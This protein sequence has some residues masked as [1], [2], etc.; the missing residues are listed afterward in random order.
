MRNYF[1]TVAAAVLSLIGALPVHAD[2]KSTAAKFEQAKVSEPTMIAFLRG[3]PK[4]GDLHNHVS[5][6]VTTEV[7]LES[8]IRQ[9]LFFDPADGLFY[10]ANNTA[11]TRVAASVL[12]T[13]DDLMAQYINKASMSGWKPAQE[14]G[15]DH[16]FSAFNYI[17]SARSTADE[18]LDDVVRSAK[19]ENEQYLELMTGTAPGSAYGKLAQIPDVSDLDKALETIRP[20]LAPFAADSKAY[21]DEREQHMASVLGQTN[22]TM[23][24]SGPINVRYIYSTSRNQSNEGFFQDLA[25]A[26]YTMQDDP[27]IVGI[28]IVAPEDYRAARVNFDKQMEIIDYLHRK[29]PKGHI[30]LHAGELTPTISPIEVMHSRIR[31]S[32]EKGDAERIGHGVSIAWEDNLDQLFQEMKQKGTAIEI[33]L[34]SNASILGVEGDRHPWALYRKA[35]IPLCL[36]TDDEGVS[37]S[38]LTL[39]YVRAAQTY[40][41][42]YTELKDLARN[43]IEYSF[44]PGDGIYQSRTYSRLRPEFAG[45]RGGQW[46]P[47]AAAQRILDNSQKAAKEVQLERAFVA[48][49]K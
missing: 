29:F 22:V 8:A 47:T 23:G 21:L 15:H 5:G 7:L 48:F 13:N 30:T 41:L 42:S 9:G 39:E 45:L 17:G 46:T 36:C 11:G 12:S 20:T 37:R 40:K 2:E 6:A 49:E 28:N 18:K 35:G 4:G 10:S 38:N 16:F 44:L 31:K 3:M 32:I 34:T 25:A 33:C 26:F 27:R 1:C 14:S 24:A 43:S 19:E